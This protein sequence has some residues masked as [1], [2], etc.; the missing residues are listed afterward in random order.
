MGGAGGGGV[1]SVCGSGDGVAILCG[2][3]DGVAIMRGSGKSEGG[4]SSE[5]EERDDSVSSV[6][7]SMVAN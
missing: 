6:N 2:S 5:A 4:G 3:G 1:S 7:M